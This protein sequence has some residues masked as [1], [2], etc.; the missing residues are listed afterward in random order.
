MVQE[1]EMYYRG[2]QSAGF[3]VYLLKI[4][5]GERLNKEDKI[6]KRGTDLIATLRY[7]IFINVRSSEDG[8]LLFN[9]L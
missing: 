4:M 3:A 5:G 6:E 9:I 8:S 2:Y 7:P 1:A